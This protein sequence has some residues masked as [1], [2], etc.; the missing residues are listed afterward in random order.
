M[1]AKIEALKLKNREEII[2]AFN[3]I[4]RMNP[5]DQKIKLLIDTFNRCNG[6]DVFHLNDFF[7]CGDCRKNLKNFWF[8]VIE[9]WKKQ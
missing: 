4:P 7:S 1:V 2:E 9:E 3:E 8:N 5:N 6:V